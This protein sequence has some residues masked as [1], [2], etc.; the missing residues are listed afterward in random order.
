MPQPSKN[1][2]Q[3]ISTKIAH[4]STWLTVREDKIITLGGPKGIYSIVDCKPGVLVIAMTDAD[5]I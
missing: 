1:P 3:T 4:Q 5:E 2:W